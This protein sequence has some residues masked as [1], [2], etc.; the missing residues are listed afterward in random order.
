MDPRDIE[1]LAQLAERLGQLRGNRSYRALSKAATGL[2]VHDGRQ[3]ALP[4]STISDLLNGKSAPS[5]DT[6]II[7]LTVCGLDT[8]EAQ[9]PWLDAYKRVAQQHQR[10]PPTTLRVRDAR[11]RILGVHAAIQATEQPSYR[12]AGDELPVY[13]PRDLDAELRT[14]ITAASQ[15]GGFVLLT[16][17]SSVGK[18]R[19]LFEAI[20]TVVPDWWLLHPAD[21]DT[22]GQFAAAPTARTV[23][24]LDELQRYLDHS[25]GL[26]G[27]AVRELIG[28]GVEMV[29]TLWPGEYAIRTAPP[30]VG[31]PDPHAND[32]ELLGLAELVAVPEEFSAEE[33]RRAEQLVAD[34]RIRIALNTPDAG[35]T[36]VMAAGPQLVQHWEQAPAEH[37]F[38]KAVVTAARDARRVGARAPVTCE[39]LAAAAPSYLTPNQRATAPAD[40]LNQ[41]LT[42][43]TKSL[44]GAA[45][46]LSA[47][48]A[49]MGIGQIAGYQVADYLHQ[50][51]LRVRRT[52]RLPDTVWQA[53]VEHHHPDD[54][55]RLTVSAHSRGRHQEVEALYRRSIHNGD[56]KDLGPLVEL[57]VDQGRVDEA[58]TFL[59]THAN[60]GDTQAAYRSAEL[61][62]KHGRVDEAIILLRTHADNG[63]LEAAYRL[64]E[65][66]AEHGRTDELAQRA[67]NG[68]TFAVGRLSGL[69]AKQGRVDEAI[70]VLRTHAN[71]GDVYDVL[72]LSN[73]LTKQGCVDEA[74]TFLR[75]HADNGHAEAASQLAV[76]L[77]KQ[78]RT[79]ELA[80]RADNGDPNAA[81]QLA[82]LL[83]DQGRIDDAAALLRTHA[84]IGDTQAA[85]GLA[86][87]LADHGRVDELTA[88]MVA[89][90]QGAAAALRAM[91]RKHQHG[92]RYQAR[93]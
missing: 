74:L 52:T 18:T 8:V 14:R 68:D 72:R 7:Y 73:L 50:H 41:A 91:R 28:A 54:V 12:E 19:A 80:Q 10:R 90:N 9:R 59:R 29:A 63:D 61:L 37:C 87:L 64:A 13:V 47:V 4:S 49:G 58:I 75:T 48:D 81:Y 79:D 56:P 69:L 30:A 17:G 71:S 40:W 1:T 5:R 33:R 53:L 82:V 31:Q 2:P 3:S 26:P 77:A 67:D 92:L 36:Q 83:A 35:F 23:V 27:A 44:H 93:S 11:P 24:W 88:E 20:K 15:Q 22:I 43:A 42:Y 38:G 84:D 66:L 55:D 57:L 45:A 46:A 89:G 6:V 76:V 34:R 51:A 62:A 39:F 60:S 25:T 70:A 21:A 16:G 32:R 85:Y 78:G 65:L 86:K